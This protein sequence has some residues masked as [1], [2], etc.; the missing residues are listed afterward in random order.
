MTSQASAARPPLEL[1]G[2]QLAVRAAWYRG[3]TSNALV[4][5]RESL[6][7]QDPDELAEWLWAAYG[8]PDVRQIDGL[9]GGDMLRSKF[10]I[11]S[12][13]ARDDA[14]VDYTFVQ[15]GVADRFIDW[16]ILCGN[17]SSAIG[18]FAVDEG[19]VATT[20]PE[21]RV[22]V[23][24]TNTGKVIHLTVR[25]AGGM[26]ATSGHLS[27]A[28]VP[29]TGSAIDLDFR[30]SA[31][32]QSGLVLPTGNRRDVLD[33]MGVGS[34]DVSIVDVSLPVVFVAAQSLGVTGAE[35]HGELVANVDL[36][37]RATAVRR[38][39]AVRLGWAAS[40]S[41][42][43]VDARIRPAVVLVGAPRG[44]SDLQGRAQ[45]ADSCDLHVR[46]VSNVN[47]HKAFMG[48]GSICAGVAANLEGTVVNAVARPSAHAAGVYRLAH[49]SGTTDVA[50]ETD[51]TDTE[52]AI[53]RASLQRTARRMFDGRVLVPVSRLP[54]LDST[55]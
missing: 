5:R 21:T 55:N 44:W 46:A 34:V 17:I 52:P 35:S 18:P 47:V 53:L 3:G 4:V 12:S 30:E 24:N 20:G 1:V 11:V 36:R 43:D 16:S 37:E 23:F 48:T 29:G 10:A 7:T 41:T 49:P 13:S 54:W 9:G 50:V 6:P 33:V 26:A 51:Q 42:A 40:V 27:I 14:D 2:D 25:T 28:G 15:L 22:R 39:A 31:G 19:L 32:T 45:P 8:T 38:A